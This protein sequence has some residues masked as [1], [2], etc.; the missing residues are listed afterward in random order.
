MP[1]GER[2][3]D[4][5]LLYGGG[6]LRRNP[7]QDIALRLD[8]LLI[9]GGG[10]SGSNLFCPMKFERDRLLLYGAPDFRPPSPLGPS[11]VLPLASLGVRGAPATDRAEPSGSPE[12]A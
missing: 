9:Y 6:E 11:A 12:K 10:E 1:R 8:R 5:L 3:G 7:N 2:T 4:R